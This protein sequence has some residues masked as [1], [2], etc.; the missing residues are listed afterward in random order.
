MFGEDTGVQSQRDII[1]TRTSGHRLRD[2]AGITVL[3]IIVFALGFS[4]GALTWLGP[5]LRGIA[6]ADSNQNN[7]VVR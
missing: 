2:L 3:W 7:E 1:I 4:C 5:D 6:A